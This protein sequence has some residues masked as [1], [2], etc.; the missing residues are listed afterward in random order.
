MC[1]KGVHLLVIRISV[2]KT[3]IYFAEFFTIKLDLYHPP[4]V[5]EINEGVEIFSQ[6]F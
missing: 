1:D 5:T 6:N 2:L 3:F 4:F